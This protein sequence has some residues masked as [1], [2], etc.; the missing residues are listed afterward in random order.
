MILQHFFLHIYIYSR[1]YANLFAFSHV[2]L[3]HD[4]TVYF[5]NVHFVGWSINS[6]VNG[7]SREKEFTY[8]HHSIK[9]LK[10]FGSH[11]SKLLHDS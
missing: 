8:K 5:A 4:L 2:H 10:L 3:H 9:L 6:I 11:S 1:K 7:K